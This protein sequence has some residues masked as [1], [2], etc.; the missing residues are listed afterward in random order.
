[1]TSDGTGTGTTQYTWN[2]EGR[3]ATVTPW[4]GTATTYVYDGDGH[5]VQDTTAQHLFWYGVDGNLMGET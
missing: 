4:G 2:A 5:R 3:T 1:M